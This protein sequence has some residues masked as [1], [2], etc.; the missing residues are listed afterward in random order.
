MSVIAPAISF[1]WQTIESYGIDAE[2][3]FSAEGIKQGMATDPHARVPVEV[4]DRIRARAIEKLDVD[5][6]GLRVA[7]YLH[8]S[9]FG[10]LGYAW[11]ASSTLRSAL[12]RLSTYIKLFNYDTEVELE[13]ADDML[14]VTDHIYCKSMNYPARDDTSLAILV[15]MCR[16]NCGRTFRPESVWIRHEKPVDEMPWLE[17]FGCPVTFGSKVNRFSIPLD[18]VDRKLS[19]ANAQLALINDQLIARDIARLEKGDIIT[20]VRSIITEKL[21]SGCFGEKCIADEI[22]LTVRSMHRKLTQRGTNFS[23]LLAEVRQETAI[24]YLRDSS[25]SLTEIAFLLG[26][27]QASSFSRAYRNWTGESPSKARRKLPA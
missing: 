5:S 13:E 21:S 26:F 19:S 6:F 3:F 1:I 23:T 2:P 27:S 18:F 22:Q 14:L 25:L 8:P 7:D 17:F 10:A 4:L 24:R 15:Q 9:H 12:E 16:F 20:R 11:L